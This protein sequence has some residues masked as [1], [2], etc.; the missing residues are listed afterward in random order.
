[1]TKTITAAKAALISGISEQTILRHIKN[2]TLQATKERTQWIISDSEFLSYCC[3]M[4]DDGKVK[5]YFPNVIADR[6]AHFIQK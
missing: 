6:Y 3:D 4:W 2:G 1:M 5:M